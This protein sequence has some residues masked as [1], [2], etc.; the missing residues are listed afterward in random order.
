MGMIGEKL[1][2]VLNNTDNESINDIWTKIRTEIKEVAKNVIGY[3][4]RRKRNDW[5]DE[6][7]LIKRVTVW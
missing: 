4:N 7:C 6:E 1:E 5:F 2:F 3:Q